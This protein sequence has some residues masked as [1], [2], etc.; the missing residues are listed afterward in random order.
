MAKRFAPASKKICKALQEDGNTPRIA[1]QIAMVWTCCKR[2]FEGIPALAWWA[3]TVR[4]E[5]LQAVLRFTFDSHA[6]ARRAAGSRIM[7]VPRSTRMM[8]LS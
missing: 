4:L 7:M 2:P 8:P 5:I 3:W 1:S 6:W